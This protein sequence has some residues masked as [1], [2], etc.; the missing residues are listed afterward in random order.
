MAK[1]GELPKAARGLCY[2]CR[3]IQACARDRGPHEDSSE[4][5][6]GGAAPKRHRLILGC[7]FVRGGQTLRSVL[8]FRRP[9]AA[10]NR[11]MVS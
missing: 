6:V 11:I 4:E 8:K 10:A 9:S 1:I 5:L 3:K 2:G 7:R